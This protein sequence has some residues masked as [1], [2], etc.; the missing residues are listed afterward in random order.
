M[1]DNVNSTEGTILGRVPGQQPDSV[2]IT[3]LKAGRKSFPIELSF[4]QLFLKR[5]EVAPPAGRSDLVALF[6]ISIADIIHGR[7]AGTLDAFRPGAAR[8]LLPSSA[9]FFLYCSHFYQFPFFY[10]VKSICKVLHSY[11]YINETDL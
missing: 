11:G 10:M 6:C 1:L 2:Y 5:K 4:T 3:T 9:T 7:S 8:F